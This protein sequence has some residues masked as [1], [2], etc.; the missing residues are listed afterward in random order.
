MQLMDANRTARVYE[1]RDELARYC[2]P[3][4]GRDPNRK[5]AWANSICILFLIIGIAG[6]KPGAIQL[7]APPPLPAEMAPII[8]EPPAPPPQQEQAQQVQPKE[9]TKPEAPQV[10]VA[11]P[12]SPA[13]A[14]SVPTMGNVLAPDGTPTAPP[15][16]P[17]QPVEKLQN[18]PIV[19]KS[20]GGSE[21]PMAYPDYFQDRGEHGSVTFSF[22][23][24]QAGLVTDAKVE[25]SSG[26]PNLDNY[27]LNQIKK[28]W[29]IPPTDGNQSYVIT[30]NF[31]P[32]R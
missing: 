32:G 16:N 7:H 13:V 18:R 4:T 11:V 8:V 28:H 5:F 27:A 22:T 29:V 25:S 3:R 9:E 31:V 1:L 6:A 14:F 17:M 12:D 24:N 21:R 26:F 20:Y 10:V 15:L 2:L 19:L 23:V 30:I